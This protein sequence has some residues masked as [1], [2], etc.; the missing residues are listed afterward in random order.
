MVHQG[1]DCSLSFYSQNLGE[2]V[3]LSTIKPRGLSICRLLLSLK[4][5]L[6]PFEMLTVSSNAWLFAPGFFYLILQG[7]VLVFQIVFWDSWEEDPVLYVSICSISVFYNNL[8]MVVSHMFLIYNQND[9]MLFHMK[10]NT[11]VCY[12]FIL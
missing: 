4:L 2:K 8:N 6:Q 7:L 5:T 3:P 10:I 9:S 1:V 11:Y 12:V